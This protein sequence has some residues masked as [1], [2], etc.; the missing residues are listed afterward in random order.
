MMISLSAHFAKN[1][2]EHQTEL[3]SSKDYLSS[4][5]KCSIF[6]S[7]RIMCSNWG[8]KFHGAFYFQGRN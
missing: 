4:K 5:T 7:F 2:T 3:E 1:K 8:Q 6:S